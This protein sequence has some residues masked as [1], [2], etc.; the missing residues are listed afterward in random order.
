MLFAIAALGWPVY[1]KPHLD[2][3]HQADAIYVLGG[4]GAE[5]YSVGLEVAL[6]GYASHVVMS[7]PIGAGSVWLTDLCTH[8]RYSF[9]VTCVEPQPPTTRGEARE[10]RR[11]AESEGWQSVIVVTFMPHISRARY[12]L[13]RCF[14]GDLMM[15]DSEVELSLADWAWNYAYQTAGYVRA[16]LQSDC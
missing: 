16:A 11:L 13:E 14:D 9:T 7:N 8:Q 15:N 10:L 2:E 4:P 6:K 12:V 5:R 3:L 1:V